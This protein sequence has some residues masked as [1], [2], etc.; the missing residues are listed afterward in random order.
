MAG[1]FDEE[2][3]WNFFSDSIAPATSLSCPTEIT[4]NSSSTEEY[5]ST[6]MSFLKVLGETLVTLETYKVSIVICAL[7]FFVKA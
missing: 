1:T 6:V 4:E 3:C 5:V 7:R 2:D